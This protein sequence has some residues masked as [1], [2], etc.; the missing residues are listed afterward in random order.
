VEPEI[1]GGGVE[2]TRVTLYRLHQVVRS[3]VDDFGRGCCSLS[4]LRRSP[5]EPLKIEAT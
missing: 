5:F 3:V 4:C 2:A 1:T